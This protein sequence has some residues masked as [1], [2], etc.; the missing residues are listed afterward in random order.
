MSGAWLRWIFA[1]LGAVIV[2]GVI[3]FFVYW[4]DYARKSN[5]ACALQ[6]KVWDRATDTCVPAPDSQTPSVS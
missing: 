4:S 1:V 6:E 5:R 3:L 2:L